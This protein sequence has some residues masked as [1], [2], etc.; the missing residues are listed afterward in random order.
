MPLISILVTPLTPLSTHRIALENALAEPYVWNCSNERPPSCCN[1]VNVQC[2]E[3]SSS[4]DQEASFIAHLLAV[5][6]N[7]EEGVAVGRTLGC[8][9]GLILGREFGCDVG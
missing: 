9:L 3:N 2:K 6:R 1:T 7:N 8:E 5:A 4:F